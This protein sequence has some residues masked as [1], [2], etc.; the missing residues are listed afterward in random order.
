[1]LQ[2]VEASSQKAKRLHYLLSL[3]ES[4]ATDEPEGTVS[5]KMFKIPQTSEEV[6]E[7]HQNQHRGIVIIPRFQHHIKHGSTVDPSH[8]KINMLRHIL[9]ETPS[10][11]TNMHWCSGHQL[12]KQGKGF[13]SGQRCIHTCKYSHYKLPTTRAVSLQLIKIPKPTSQ[14]I[15]R[16]DQ[17]AQM[18]AWAKMHGKSIRQGN[19]RQDDTMERG[20]GHFTSELI[21][22]CNGL[23][24]SQF[25]FTQRRR[26]NFKQ[27][28]WA[29]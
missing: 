18:R 20:V 21:R 5:N 19:V 9:R 26:K 13:P 16:N 12:K 4:S 1:M 17:Q 3:K 6:S 25:E 15:T 27:K 28:Q 23:E 24:T 10:H 8:Y 7:L 22:K 14:E 29:C 2:Y 11:C